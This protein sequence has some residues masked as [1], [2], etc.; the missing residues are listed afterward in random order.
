MA[1]KPLFI[2][3][4]A[5]SAIAGF[6]AFLIVSYQLTPNKPFHLTVAQTGSMEPRIPSGSIVVTVPL[7]DLQSLNPQQIITFNKPLPANSTMIRSIEQVQG[8]NYITKADTS[9]TADKQI[10]NRSTITGLYY[11][12]IPY[13]GYLYIIGKSPFMLSLLIT[14]PI[15]LL[16]TLASQI[17]FGSLTGIWKKDYSVISRIKFALALS[18]FI[19]ILIT[20]IAVIVHS[21]PTIA[22]NADSAKITP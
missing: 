17:I 21:Q 9:Q 22:L 1:R 16:L 10:I 2:I 13:L 8:N 5:L 7:N 18:L 20:P 6:L 12:H 11:T 15:A 4:L 19:A 14:V 3:N